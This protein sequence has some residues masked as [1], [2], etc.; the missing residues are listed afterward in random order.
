MFTTKL[1]TKSKKEPE[2][3]NSFNFAFK[4]YKDTKPGIGFGLAEKSSEANPKAPSTSFPQNL[5]V[6]ENRGVLEEKKIPKKEQV[7]SISKMSLEEFEKVG[8]N[9]KTICQIFNKW[10][11]NLIGIA[12]EM[13][14]TESDIQDY[15]A[16]LLDFIK[17]LYSQI[18]VVDLANQ[19][20]EQQKSM[21]LDLKKKQVT[22]FPSNLGR[23][24]GYSRRY[25]GISRS[26][27]KK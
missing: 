6:P 2:Q 14:E 8:M 1:D 10:R 13:K 24:K 27:P 11:T 16:Q 20:A 19:I 17:K 22:K 25:Y 5:I 9:S 26:V 21:L 3:K 7:E 23:I 18:Q 4:D 12:N 15:E